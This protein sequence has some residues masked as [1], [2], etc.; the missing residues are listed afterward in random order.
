MSIKKNKKQ[1]TVFTTLAESVSYQLI[2]PVGEY[3]RNIK[4]SYNS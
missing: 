1:K 4:D 3:F 2:S